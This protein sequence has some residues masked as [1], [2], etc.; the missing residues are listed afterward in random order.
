MSHASHHYNPDWLSDEALIANFVARQGEFT[1]LRDELSRVPQSGNVQ[2]YLLVG[3][4]GAGKTTLLK[5]LAAA[6]RQD[7]D[8]NDHLIAL[9]FPEELYQVKK[10]LRFLVGRLRCTGR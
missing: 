9:S 5:R 8:L 3:V 10:S 4:R 6:I 2:H 1:F 7:N